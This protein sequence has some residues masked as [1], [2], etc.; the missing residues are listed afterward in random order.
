MIYSLNP[1]AAIT[2]TLYHMDSK[3]VAIGHKDSKHVYLEQ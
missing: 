3:Q 1:W 2:D